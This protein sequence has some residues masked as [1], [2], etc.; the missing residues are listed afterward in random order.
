MITRLLIRALQL[1][2]VTLAL[3]A[4]GLLGT[5]HGGTSPC[6]LCCTLSSTRFTGRCDGAGGACGRGR[7]LQ[8]GHLQE[9]RRIVQHARPACLGARGEA[10]NYVRIRCLVRILF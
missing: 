9:H 5:A 10:N 2:D 8:V 7:R 1:V 3:W 6:F 4:R